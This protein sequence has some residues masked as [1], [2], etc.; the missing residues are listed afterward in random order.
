MRTF[1][2][3]GVITLAVI[4]VL[5]M[6]GMSVAPDSFRLPEPEATV[7]V[8]ATPQVVATVTATATVTAIVTPAPSGASGA[9]GGQAS[10]PETPAA[11]SSPES[12]SPVRWTKVATVS[13]TANKKS[14]K[15]WLRGDAQ[16]LTWKL[17]GK[18]FHFAQIYVTE[19]FSGEFSTVPDA[20]PEVRGPG[21]TRLRLEE[22]M[23]Y[24]D[25][26]S[27]CTWSVAIWDQR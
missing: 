17:G 11:T 24:L 20:A 16:K 26:Y 4:V 9:G 23:Y 13:G 8:T 3:A 14:A 2:L 1:V 22:G 5:A 12:G 19:A 18:G 6:I 15:F 21:S 25:V 10:S 7:T 27:D